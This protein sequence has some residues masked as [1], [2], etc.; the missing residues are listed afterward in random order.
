MN[1][2]HINVVQ[3]IIAIWVELNRGKRHKLEDESNK[4]IKRRDTSRET[5]VKIAYVV[6]LGWI[7]CL[8]KGPWDQ[9][10]LKMNSVPF[11]DSTKCPLYL[12]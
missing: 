5:H 6:A 1:T 4:M 10:V 9:N 7:M 12:E 3:R 2:N 11:T 8:L